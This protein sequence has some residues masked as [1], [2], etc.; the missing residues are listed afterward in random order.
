[1]R[2]AN[3]ARRIAAATAVAMSL[4][5]TPA[6]AQEIS[7]AHLSAARQAI[8]AIHATDEFDSVLPQ[9]A[10]ALKSE[11][12]QKNPDL[13]DLINDTVDEKAIELASRRSDLEREAALAYAR[14]FSE[15]ELNDISTFYQSE[16]GKKLISDGPI[17]TREVIKAGNIWQRGIVRDLAQMVGEQIAS[18]VKTQDEAQP[19]D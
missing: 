19:A 5:F 10:R 18:V 14:V 13:V 16:T 7:D 11:L 15:Q 12:T 9:A 8:T 3:C 6:G 2:L 1:M 17:V 4:S